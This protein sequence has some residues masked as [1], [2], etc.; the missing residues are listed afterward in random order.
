M[1]QTANGK[2]LK[3]HSQG[4]LAAPMATPPGQRACALQVAAQKTHRK[5]HMEIW[6]VKILWRIP[7]HFEGIISWFQL[8]KAPARP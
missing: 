4:V 6:K 7:H 3:R 8:L 2:Q 1:I 5:I